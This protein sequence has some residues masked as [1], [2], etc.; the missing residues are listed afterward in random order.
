VRNQLDR[1]LQILTAPFWSVV[2]LI[3]LFLGSWL[4]LAVSLE[5]HRVWVEV[6]NHFVQVVGIVIGGTWAFIVFVV[7]KWKIEPHLNIKIEV[8]EIKRYEKL[9]AVTMKMNFANES[10]KRVY[11]AYS[12]IETLAAQHILPGNENTFI[13]RLTALVETSDTSNFANIEMTLGEKDFISYRPALMKGTWFDPGESICCSVVEFFPA[14]TVVASAK[15]I[16]RF[17]EKEPKKIKY[18][19]RRLK[20]EFLQTEVIQY[21]EDEAVKVDSKEGERLIEKNKIITSTSWIE[22]IL[23]EKWIAGQKS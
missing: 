16:V 6:L 18:S 13:E 8:T 19:Y 11:I 7:Q 1:F 10:E 20:T 17:S 2:F 5:N 21:A 23:S 15:V 12:G 4:T 9:V 14:T 22:F 3:G